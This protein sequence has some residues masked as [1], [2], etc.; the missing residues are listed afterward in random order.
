MAAQPGWPRLLLA[1][2]L[3]SPGVDSP[4]GRLG[5]SIVKQLVQVLKGEG[6]VAKQTSHRA[7]FT[8]TLPFR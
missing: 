5:L 1:P 2:W 3:E 4:F 7:V 6:I 8:V